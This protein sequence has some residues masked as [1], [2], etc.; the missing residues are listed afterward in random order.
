M[1]DLYFISSPILT[2]LRLGIKI[3]EYVNELN[4]HSRRNAR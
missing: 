1:L 3:D 2:G 4:L